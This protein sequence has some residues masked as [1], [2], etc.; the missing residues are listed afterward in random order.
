MIICIY[1]LP[2]LYKCDIIYTSTSGEAAMRHYPKLD[3]N[4]LTPEQ[5]HD[6]IH[7]RAI[8]NRFWGWFFVLY[9]IWWD[10]KFYSP[11]HG[12][13]FSFDWFI[14]FFKEPTLSMYFVIPFLI[15][16][17]GFA[18]WHGDMRFS[19]ETTQ[20]YIPIW[21]WVYLKISAFVFIGWMIYS[22]AH[23]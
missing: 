21:V 22:L 9:F 2:F 19:S 23:L 5:A 8:R 15:I 11:I 6:F 14:N 10:Y 17:N 1:K 7:L 12:V 16:Y 13:R 18:S 3:L 4:N 20:S